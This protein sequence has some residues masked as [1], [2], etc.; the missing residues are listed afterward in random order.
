MGKIQNH[1]H[2][3]NTL[4]DDRNWAALEEKDAFQVKFM[5]ER[6]RAKESE[7]SSR[8]RRRRGQKNKTNQSVLNQE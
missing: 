3:G 6:K 2:K 7:K 1:T 5:D 4:P 8:I